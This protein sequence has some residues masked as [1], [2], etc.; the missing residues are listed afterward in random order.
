MLPVAA[1]VVGGVLALRSPPGAAYDI[2]PGDDLFATLEKLEAGDEVVIH[3]G[4]YR[5]PGFYE[6]RWDGTDDAPVMVRGAPGEARPVLVGLPEQD[7]VDLEGSH[8]TLS[9]LELRRGGDGLRLGNVDHA[10][11]K[12]LVIHDLEDIGISCNLPGKVCDAVTI[13][14]SEI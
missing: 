1:L 5:S 8:F 14:D 10:T 11:F 12:D 6:A 9:H 7:I 4:T 2:Q 13:R 3:A